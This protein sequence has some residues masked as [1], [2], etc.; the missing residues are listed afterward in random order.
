MTDSAPYA[1]HPDAPEDTRAWPVSPPYQVIAPTIARLDAAARIVEERQGK[2]GIPWCFNDDVE[3]TAAREN[4]TGSTLSHSDRTVRFDVSSTER[5]FD[6]D[7]QVRL[8]LWIAL[9]AARRP[10]FWSDSITSVLHAVVL[11]R[12]TTLAAVEHATATG[13]GRPDAVADRIVRLLCAA[14]T[15]AVSYITAGQAGPPNDAYL[16]ADVCIMG[17]VLLG[18]AL[19][20]ATARRMQTVLTAL[21]TMGLTDHQ[22]ERSYPL[23]RRE[24]DRA[25]LQT[26]TDESPKRSPIGPRR[27]M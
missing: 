8:V 4:D 17:A 26:V 23:A 6:P 12:A 13:L 5:V 19:D 2:N 7:D 18:P 21:E 27:T 22:R 24:I 9:R 16:W 3:Q 15:E 25:L 20:G 11:R 1:A 10:G 14:G